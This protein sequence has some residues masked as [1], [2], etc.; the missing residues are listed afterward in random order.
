MW[1]EL[2]GMSGYMMEVIG[3]GLYWFMW[4]EVFRLSN[5]SSKQAGL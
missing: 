5:N 1:F 3:A 2:L 4:F